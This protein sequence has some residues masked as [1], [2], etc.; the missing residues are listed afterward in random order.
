MLDIGFVLYEKGAEPGTLDANWVHSSLGI[1]TGK[2]TGGPVSGFVGRYQ[3]L[4]FDQNGE[5]M[6][7]RELDIQKDGAQYD[8]TWLHN[9]AVTSQG[10]GLEVAEGLAVGWRGIVD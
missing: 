2:A 4:Y 3:I 9:G 5:L 7:E 8:L 1:G 6:V 10:I